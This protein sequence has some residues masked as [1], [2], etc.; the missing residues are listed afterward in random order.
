[1]LAPRVTLF[2]VRPQVGIRKKLGEVAEKLSCSQKP[3]LEQLKKIQEE[4]DVMEKESHFL[5]ESLIYFRRIGERGL[6]RAPF[7]SCPSDLFE[8]CPVSA[9]FIGAGIL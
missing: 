9:A 6:Y 2:S 4:Q 7:P 1:M 3:L 8:V 5:A